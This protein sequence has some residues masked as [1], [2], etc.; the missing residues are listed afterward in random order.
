[1]SCPWIH[2]CLTAF[3]GHGGSS[4]RG[5]AT[6][7]CGLGEAVAAASKT[8]AVHREA[9]DRCFIQWYRSSF[10]SGDLSSDSDPCREKF[11]TYRGCV[12]KELREQGVEKI[13]HFEYNATPEREFDA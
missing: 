12:L 7:S 1:M 5:M 6:R 4:E 9:Y 2:M 10:L 8:C 3:C 11:D 13:A